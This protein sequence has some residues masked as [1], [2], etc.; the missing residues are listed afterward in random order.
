MRALLATSNRHKLEELRRALPQWEVELLD[1]DDVPEESGRSYEDNA[2]IKAV[3]GT[4]FAASGVWVIGEDS[5]IEL[6]AL[7][8]A[9]G[10]CSA[11]WAEDGVAR[12]LTE[13]E[14]AEDRRARY[15]CVMVA[16]RPDGSERVGCGTLEGTI[17]SERR[18][19]AGF[20]YDPIFVPDGETAT[21][22]ELGDS[23]K[24]LHS[25]RTRAAASLLLGFSTEA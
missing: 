14:G 20:G 4:A 22:A 13:L 25:H 23:W 7:G 12:A 18:G 3:H 8:G 1:R 17:A 2:R 11:R 5:G 19:A 24:R 9:P 16:R 15:V 10:T 21:V 6:A